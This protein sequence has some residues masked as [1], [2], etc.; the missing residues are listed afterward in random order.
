KE[1]DKLE[2]SAAELSVWGVQEGKQYPCIMKSKE[3]FPKIDLFICSIQ[4]TPDAEFLHLIIKY[5]DKTVRLGPPS[6]LHQVLLILRLLLI[7]CVTVVLVII[8]RWQ[9]KLTAEMNKL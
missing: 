1:A 3:T 4:N 9:K 5:G 8:C 7:P 6:L 2:M